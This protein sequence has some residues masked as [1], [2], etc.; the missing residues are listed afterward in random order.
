MFREN[1]QRLNK[2]MF[3]TIDS[4]DPRYVKE[5]EEGRAGLFYKIVFY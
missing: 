3:G 5:I 4:M 2:S 1:D